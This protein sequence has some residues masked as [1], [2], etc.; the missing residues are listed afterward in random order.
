MLFLGLIDDLLIQN[1]FGIEC[2]Q[3]TA[4]FPRDT[5][6]FGLIETHTG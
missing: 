6:Q 3:T 1:R 4:I 2:I 5:A